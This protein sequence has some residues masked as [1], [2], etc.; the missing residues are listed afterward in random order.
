MRYVTKY[1]WAAVPCGNVAKFQRNHKQYLECISFQHALR[2]IYLCNYVS[3]RT[4]VDL[5]SELFVC[6]DS[7]RVK[8]VF[9]Q[10]VNINILQL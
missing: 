5:P 9:L 4:D 2:V 1:T 7:R 6:T 3:T 10:I 8:R